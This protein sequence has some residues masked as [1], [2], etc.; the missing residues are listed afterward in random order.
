MQRF[1]TAK[2][3][4][5]L[6]ITVGWVVIAIAAIAFVLPI[7]PQVFW[8]KIIGLVA[9]CFSGFMLIAI[10]QMGLAQIATAEN[11]RRMVELLEASQKGVG[12]QS[13][14]NESKGPR[15]EPV[16]GRIK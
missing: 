3:M 16:I 8:V 11:T 5:A 14:P 7:F 2:L 10:G 6:V 1:T 4:L 12:K 15:V 13:H 9:A